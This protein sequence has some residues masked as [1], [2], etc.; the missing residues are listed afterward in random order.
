MAVSMNMQYFFHMH[1]NIKI[2]LND[3][4]HTMMFDVVQAVY[5]CFVFIFSVSLQIAQHWL[6]DLYFT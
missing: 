4:E 1:R 2:S 3:T 5:V 6:V